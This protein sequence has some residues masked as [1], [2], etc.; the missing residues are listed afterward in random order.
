MNDIRIHLTNLTLFDV[1]YVFIS[2]KAKF[3]FSYAATYMIFY[4]TYIKQWIK[5]SDKRWI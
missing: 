5:K 1:V 4:A 3:N 2:V